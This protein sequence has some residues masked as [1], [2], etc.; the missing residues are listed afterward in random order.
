LAL[1][2]L[3][4]IDRPTDRI[5]DIGTGSGVIAVG[6]ASRGCSSILAVDISEGECKLALGNVRTNRV[7]SAVNVLVGDLASLF[8]RNAFSVV[9]SNPPQLPTT[10]PNADVRDFAGPTGYEAIQN[11]ISQCEGCLIPKG[12]LW[13]YVLGFLGIEERTGKFLSLFERL[14]RFGFEPRVVRRL[15]KKLSQSSRIHAAIPLIRTLYP[16]SDIAKMY[17]NMRSY[18]AYVVQALLINK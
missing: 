16:M 14:K 11:I 2:E 10:T 17:P 4:A 3:V 18:E 12:N 6:I 9:I 13:L 5:L 1:A 15:H 8:A 7:G